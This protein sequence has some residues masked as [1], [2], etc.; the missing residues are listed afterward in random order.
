MLAG[1]V[2]ILVGVLFVWRMEVFET[3]LFGI[4]NKTAAQIVGGIIGWLYQ[5]HVQQTTIPLMH[6]EMFDQH[7]NII[8]D[9]IVTFRIENSDLIGEEEQQEED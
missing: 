8:P 7:G 3:R 5:Q 6:P 2:A 4:E 9:E 1:C